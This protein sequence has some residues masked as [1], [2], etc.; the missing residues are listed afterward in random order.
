MLPAGRGPDVRRR[1]LRRPSSP[2][3]RLPTRRSAATA[4]SS[5]GSGCWRW[6]RGRGDRLV[7]G[8]Q[9]DVGRRLG[10]RQ[11]RLDPAGDQLVGQLRRSRAA[12]RGCRRSRSCRRRSSTRRRR[13]PR[14]SRPGP[15][16]LRRQPLDR[17]ADRGLPRLR[18]VREPQEGR[19]HPLDLGT[20]Q[21]IASVSVTS[22]TPG[23]AV[24][25]RTGTDPHGSLDSFST[26]ASGTRAGPP[27]T[28]TFTKTVSSRYVLV[29][30]TGLVPSNGR[31]LGGPRRGRRPRGRLTRTRRPAHGLAAPRRGSGPA[32]RGMPPLGSSLCRP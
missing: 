18:A 27:P 9:P 14:P 31:V 26:A 6:P 16:L 7:R 22:T 20:E 24:E 5:S 15:A 11:P 2:T 17:V 25:I 3:A 13:Q 21:K 1:R 19:G 10:R 12:G 4:P 32:P 28:C 8:L 29:W 30:I 23:A